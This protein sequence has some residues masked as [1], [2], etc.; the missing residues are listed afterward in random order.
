MSKSRPFS[1]FLLKPGYD[2]SSALKDDHSLDQSVQAD[3]LPE[4][5]TLFVLD[6][7]PKNPW[8]R[9]YFGV[10]KDLRQATKGALVFLPVSDRIFALSFGHVFHNL[11]DVSYEYD[12]GLRATLN[13]VDPE[14]IKNTDILEP[15]AARRHRTQVAV[16]SDLTFF[17]FD[18]DSTI[19]KSLTGRV[20]EE[21]QDLIRH[22][23]GASNL[24]ISS[25]V[26]ASDL[27]ELCTTLLERYRSDEFKTTFPD[28]QNIAPVRDPVVLAELDEKLLAAV[29]SKSD[30]V[31][32]AF[33]EIVDYRDNVSATFSGAG[34]SEVYDDVFIGRFYEYLDKHE[35]DVPSLNL[36][37]LKKFKLRRT[38]ENGDVRQ[39]YSIY[40]SLI[41]ETT[42]GASGATFHMADGSWFKVEN[43]YIAKLENYL[44]PLCQE[45]DLPDY[46]HADEGAYNIA[47][48]DE[49]DSFLCFD[50]TDISPVGQKQVEPCDL[51][52]IEEDKALFLH[53]KR[54]THSA[55]LSHLF[56]QGANSVELLKMDEEARDKL[57][58]LIDGNAASDTADAFKA[59]IEDVRYAVTFG[60][61]T[62][63]DKSQKSRNLPLFSRISL[64]RIM[65]MLDLWGVDRAFGYITD[66]APAKAGKK[67]PRKKA[68]KAE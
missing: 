42:L 41:F 40:R 36:S 17:D 39:S 64:M 2:A 1:I 57:G 45:I 26:A 13:C 58:A 62:H 29:R 59:P 24:R 63:K 65:K 67:K 11:K 22:V 56:N 6:S 66:A 44:D 7:Q 54:S 31:A 21:Y 28:I 23:T 38:D 9:G 50:K 20:R 3:D 14:K 35:V 19:L 4:N 37:E 47:V 46:N 34:R 53:I 48:A 51:Y 30:D 60:I 49:D 18:R 16:D 33:P 68:G 61:I 15:G 25:A 43:D 32:L 10:Q 27:P 8:W 12:F 5:A 55:E 52:K